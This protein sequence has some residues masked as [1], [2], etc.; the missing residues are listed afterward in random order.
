MLRRDFMK[1]GVASFVGVDLAKFCEDRKDR[2]YRSRVILPT[3]T[4][5]V[6]NKEDEYDCYEFDC[7]LVPGDKM[8]VGGTVWI[9]HFNSKERSI[10]IE[11]YIV[12]KV[13]DTRYEHLRPC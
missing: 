5:Q 10:S 3:H 2:K 6:Q 9:E 4:I 13:E 11:E 12:I 1:A 8:V 7:I